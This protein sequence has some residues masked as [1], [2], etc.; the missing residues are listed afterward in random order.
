MGNPLKLE[1]TKGRFWKRVMDLGEAKSQILFAVPM[2]LSNV[3]YFLITMISV[4]FSGHLG[5][6]ELAA[7]T[8][9][10]SWATVTGFAF[11][12]CKLPLITRVSNE[13]GGGN[14]NKAKHAMAV[15]LKLSIL[16]VLAVV[17][18][19]AFG[20]D[21]WAAF[22]SDSHSIIKKFAKMT[23]LPLVSIAI[24]GVFSGIMDGVNMWSILSN[25]HSYVGYIL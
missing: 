3:F 7:S 12:F 18:T 1:V 20:H 14:P 21:I 8:L 19:L 6:V 5:E 11:M 24:Q 23:P 2:V 4:M 22:F 15:T 16:L 9:A 10:D 13:L 17:L 25:L